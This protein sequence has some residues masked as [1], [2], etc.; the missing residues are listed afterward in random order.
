MLIALKKNLGVVSSAARAANINRD[1]HYNWMK[2]DEAYARAVVDLQEAALDFAESKLFE[3]MNGVT[4]QQPPRPGQ[5]QPI[6]YTIPPNV[7]A[8]IFYLK[9]KGKKRG[10]V[11]RIQLGDFGDDEMSTTLDV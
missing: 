9:T 1:T 3:L 8:C 5:A 6:V 7:A 10:Y 4:V 2:S 11:E